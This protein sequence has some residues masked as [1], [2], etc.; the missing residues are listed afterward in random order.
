MLFNASPHVNYT[1]YANGLIEQW[2]IDE[3][4]NS[5]HVISIPIYYSSTNYVISVTAKSINDSA[6]KDANTVVYGGSSLTTS[7]FTCDTS[8]GNY[9][10]YMMWNTKGY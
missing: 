5:N 1:V 8:K 7:S 10:P 6:Y 9:K 2:G 3:T 4:S